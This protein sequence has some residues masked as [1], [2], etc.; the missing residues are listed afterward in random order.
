MDNIYGQT[1]AEMNSIVRLPEGYAQQSG[2]TLYMWL[3]SLWR[4]LHEGEGMIRGLQSARG[5]RMAQLYLDILEAASLQDRFGAPV[6]HR[7]LWHPISVRLSKRDTAQENMLSIGLDGEV[8]AQPA[9]SIY[10][11]GTVF[12]LGKLANLKDYATYPVDAEVAGG[13]ASIVDNIVNPTVRMEKGKDYVIRDGSIIFHR[14]NDPLGENSKFDKYDVPGLIDED[15][16]EVSDVEAV[17]WA[18][19]VLI[20]K[21]YVADHISYAL[22]ANAPSSAVVKRILN[23][24]WSSVTSGLT[25][26][27]VKT[28]MAAMLNIPVIQHEKET[29]VDIYV[30][31]DKDGNA[32]SRIVATDKGSYRV[33]LKARLR[34]EVVLGAD[35]TK[36]DLLDE[37]VRIYPFLNN[38]K[39]AEVID[40]AGAESF[41]DWEFDPSTVGE[42]HVDPSSMAL[43]GGHW[44]VEYRDDYDSSLTFS[45]GPSLESALSVE[46][47]TLYGEGESC[48]NATRHIIRE[49]PT[50]RV[51]AYAGTDFSVPLT[52]DIP[53][54]TIPSGMIRAKTEYGV[55]AM[56]DMSE[57]KKDAKGRLHFDIGGSPADVKAFWEDVWNKAD[58]MGVSMESLLGAE[59]TKVSPAAFFLNNL[60]GANTLFVVVDRSQIDDISMMRDP[61]F[62]DMLSAVVPSAIRLFLVEHRSVGDDDI[63]HMD[64]AAETGSVFAALPEAVDVAGH[65]GERVSIR[66]F[67]P[68]PA[69]VRG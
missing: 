56:W 50:Y 14:D 64:E 4:G 22:G 46:L 16:N 11:E 62:F 59:G 31:H 57:V 23:A 6:F 37:S 15:G 45:S 17:L 55:Y 66:F 38:V 53:S 21:N 36:G 26:E 10:G 5:I 40:H 69:K 51:E 68:P 3:G 58:E 13:A 60:M 54:V 9:G 28:L 34:K 44:S 2:N 12:S 8:G 65:A 42:F 49:D 39:T 47:C 63:A 43:E 24:A 7:E 19:D 20:D 33:S 41:S 52:L 1:E 48:I 25:P 30:E 32:V 67:R 35:M 29:V 18:S 61:M 27:L